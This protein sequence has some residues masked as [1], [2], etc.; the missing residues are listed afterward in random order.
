MKYGDFDDRNREYVIDRPDTPKSWSNYLGNTTYGAIITNNAGGYSF[1][2][3]GGMGRFMRMR[4]NSVPAD[5]PGRYIY[6]HD[7]DSKDFWSNA[8][9]PVGKPL[10]TYKSICR[11][12]TAYSVITSEY[13]GIASE[14][15]YFVPLDRTLE[16]W[17]VRVTNKGEIPRR[18][19]AFSYV[20]YTGNWNAIDDLLNIQYVQYTST[21]EVEDGIIDHGTNVNIPEMPHNF[22]EKDQGRH[23]FQALSGLDLVGYDTD[24]E[25]FLGP[26]RTYANPLAV[27]KGEPSGSLGY[28]DN[29]CGS[30][31][32][33]LTLEP[34]ETRE[35]LVIVGIGNAGVEGKRARET[36]ISTEKRFPM[37]TKGTIRYCYTCGGP[38]SSQ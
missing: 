35:F 37:R 19:R 4:F 34:R 6:F 30:L 28:G 10:S 23:T 29:P 1:Y 18:L 16:L 5:Q 26:Y 11:H 9:Q 15:T 24:R 32:G 22:R 31:C 25:A 21:M 14:T 20:E 17:K 27:E 2:R 36:W 13:N 12:G 7:R 8:W 38:L 33:D 3:S